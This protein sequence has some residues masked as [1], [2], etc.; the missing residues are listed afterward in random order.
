MDMCSHVG[1]LDLSSAV[2]SLPELDEE[3]KK[4]ATVQISG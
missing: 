4:A 2:E 3:P 1:L